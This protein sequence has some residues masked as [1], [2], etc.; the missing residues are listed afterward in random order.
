MGLDRRLF[1]KRGCLAA[2]ALAATPRFS[3]AGLLR[4]K[5]LASDTILVIVQLGGGNDG[6]NTVVPLGSSTYQSARPDIAIDSSQALRIDSKTGLN[7]SLSKLS[8]H[9]HAGR[10]AIVQG[11]GYPDADLSHFRSTD[12]WEAGT[13]E[14]PVTT[15]WIGR[16]LDALYAGDAQSL[17]SLSFGYDSPTAFASD[18]VT[19][20]TLFDPDEFDF[21]TDPYYPDDDASQRDAIRAILGDSGIKNRDLV[22]GAGMAAINDSA[23]LHQAID[24]YQ[25]TVVYPDN[26]PG[27]GLKLAAQSILAG[28]GARI[29]W[30]EQGGYDT[31]DNQRASQDGLLADLDGG[32]DA[33]WRDLSLHGRDS[34]VLVMTWSEFGRRV[35][36]NGSA[37][38]DHGTAAPLFLLGSKVRA[39]LYGTAPSLT[40]LDPDGNLVFGVDYRQVY[41]TILSKW[42]GADP[43]PVLGSGFSPLAFL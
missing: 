1:L 27:P 18:V 15:G 42:L 23:A 41:A 13:L 21:Q 29:Y 33:F 35:E 6:L 12:I 39:G 25:S 28:L 4:R 36:S 37:G 5:L 43:V 26:D 20:P 24:S 16:T 8:T 31:H 38:T 7:P 40:S 22:A 19:T 3:A 14:T 17:H 10:L 9:L 32:L 34:Q 11:V 30:V 2:A